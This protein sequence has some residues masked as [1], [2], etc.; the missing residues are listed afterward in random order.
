MTDVEI[1]VDILNPD[2]AAPRPARGVQNDDIND[3]T[4]AAAQSIESDATTLRRSVADPPPSGELR[5]N[6]DGSITVGGRDVMQNLNRG[7]ELWR[8]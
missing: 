7:A 4:E 3:A 6:L 2:V 8:I 5:I 1:V